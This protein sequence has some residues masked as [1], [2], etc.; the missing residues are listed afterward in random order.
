MASWGGGLGGSTPR[1]AAFIW[2][3][4]AAA[5]RQPQSGGEFVWKP[6]CTHLGGRAPGARCQLV[7]TLP[8]STAC[9][10]RSTLLACTQLTV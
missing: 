4:R 10:G 7:G 2:R 8:R 6:G 1:C 9:I 3:L 5:Q